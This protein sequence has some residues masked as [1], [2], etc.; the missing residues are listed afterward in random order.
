VKHPSKWRYSDEAFHEVKA[1]IGG[2]EWDAHHAAN[3]VFKEGEVGVY[4]NL[5][6]FEIT[7]FPFRYR[8]LGVAC[9][10]IQWPERSAEILRRGETLATMERFDSVRQLVEWCKM[11][12]E[13][14][15]ETPE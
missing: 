7:Y 4:E 13:M 9:C 2:A 11:V 8:G 14:A 10:Q 6:W 1:R 3:I 15:D 12:W 5:G